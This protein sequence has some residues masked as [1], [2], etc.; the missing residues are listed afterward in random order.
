[1]KRYYCLVAGLA[2][3]ANLFTLACNRS[4]NAKDAETEDPPPAVVENVGGTALLHVTH[5]EQYPLVA[6]QSVVTNSE[7]NVTGVV[8]ADISRTI[9]VVTVASGRIIQVL[10]RLGDRVTKGQVLMRV[11]SADVSEAISDYKQA[12]ADDVLLE[13]QLARSQALYDKGAIAKKDLEIAED[14]EEK[15]DVTLAATVER[16]R[17]LG[18]DKDHPSSIIDVRAPGTGVITDQQVT[19]AS[20]TQG[21]AGPNA[22]AIS[23]LTHVWILCDVY[24]NDLPMVRVGDYADI[25]LN[26]YPSV[27]LKGRV[28]NIGSILDPNIRTAKVRIEVENPGMLL[29]GMFVRATFRG[30]DKHSRCVVPPSAILHLHDRNWVYVAQG[31]GAFRRTEVQA[32]L[33]LSSGQQEVLSGIGRGDRIVRDALLMENTIQP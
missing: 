19:N 8:T 15:A 16:L 18:A 13:A 26:A 4:L 17:V 21:L 28:G 29:L 10:A 5:P 32:G 33:L 22:F 3:L 11:E 2:L 7:I 30:N 6:V 14:A 23:D 31:N 1:M 27:V 24:E 12:Q 20:G 25:H 9:P